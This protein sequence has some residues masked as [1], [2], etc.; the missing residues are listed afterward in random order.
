MVNEYVLVWVYNAPVN[1]FLDLLYNRFKCLKLITKHL[2]FEC[3]IN[4]MLHF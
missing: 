1:F 3:D 4:R 2:G